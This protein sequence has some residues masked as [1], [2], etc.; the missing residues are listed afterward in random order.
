MT[1]EEALKWC[2]ERSI[3]AI[4]HGRR[5]VLAMPFAKVKMSAFKEQGLTIEMRDG[6]TLAMSEPG[7]EFHDVIEA[8]RAA[9][10][11]N[12]SPCDR[13][14]E[15]MGRPTHIVELDFRQNVIEGVSLDGL[16]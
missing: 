5:I 2:G 10:S 13:A 8:A 3:I 15:A 6:F 16:R 12:L 11:E 4:F 14:A 9:W 1:N 7:D